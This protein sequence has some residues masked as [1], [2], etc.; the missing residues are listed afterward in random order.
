M[1]TITVAVLVV[2]VIGEASAQQPQ[3]G[4]M[5]A[6]SG[7][8]AAYVQEYRR[9]PDTANNVYFSW[10]QGYMSGQNVARDKNPMRDLNALPVSTQ[11]DFLKR[12]CDQKPTALFAVAAQNLFNALPPLRK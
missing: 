11:L 4:M 6:G 12:F 1:R 5:G 9:D 7:T 8:C 3:A 2:I 10:A